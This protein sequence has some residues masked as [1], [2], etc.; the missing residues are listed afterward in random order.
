M[1]FIHENHG[2]AMSTVVDGF[3]FLLP[4]VPGSMQGT[5]AALKRG[6]GVFSVFSGVISVFDGI[7][8]D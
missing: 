7:I 1:S 4:A 5:M 6:K 8:W 2:I 3:V